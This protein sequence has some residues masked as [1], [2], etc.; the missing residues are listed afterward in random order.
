M[1]KDREA[2]LPSTNTGVDLDIDDLLPSLSNNPNQWP[3]N[4]F[5]RINS[6]M[7]SMDG[8]AFNLFDDT[9]VIPA[10]EGK[11]SFHQ[12]EIFEIT[13]TVPEIFNEP[14]STKA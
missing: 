2:T 3:G 5:K 7:S 6:N 1:L 11:D 9:I 10:D 4:Q 8:K 13:P 12:S 14:S